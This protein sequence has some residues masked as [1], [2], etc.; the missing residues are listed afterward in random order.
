MFFVRRI[1]KYISLPNNIKYIASELFIT[2]N[3]N[4]NYTKVEIHGKNNN[5]HNR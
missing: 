1:F 3:F 2:N 5:A 4:I